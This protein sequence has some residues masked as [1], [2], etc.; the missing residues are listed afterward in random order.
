MRFFLLL[1]GLPLGLWAQIVVRDNA[2]GAPVE[3]AH[4]LFEEEGGRRD[5]AVTDAQGQGPNLLKAP[6]KVTISFVGYQSLEVKLK[7]DQP[8]VVRLLPG[9]QDLREVVVTGQFR[10]QGESQSVFPVKVLKTA[11]FEARGAVTLNQV[12]NNQLNIRISQDN[13]L[14]S[15]ISMQG[16]SGENVKILVDGVPLVGRLNGNIDLS[17]INMAEVERIEVVEGPLSV[18]YGSNALAGTINIITKKPVKGQNT[19]SISQYYE[20]VG[21]FQTDLAGMVALGGPWSA[22]WGG[23][24]YFLDG[25]SPPGLDTGRSLQWNQ[26]EQYNAYAGLGYSGKRLTLYLDGRYLWEQIKDKGERRSAF[27]DY[28]FDTWFTTQ[29]GMGTVSG[30]YTPSA[31]GNLQYM[32][33]YSVFNRSRIRYNT[34]LVEGGQ[35]PTTNPSDHD[36]TRY[37]N[38]VSRSSWNSTTASPWNYQVG[39]DLNWESASGDRIGG[40]VQTMLDVALFGSLQWQPTNRITIQPA[41]RVSYN[42]AFAADPVP[43]LNL[44][45]AASDQWVWRASYARGFR[46]PSI[47]ELHM[48]FIDANHNIIG[49]PNLTPEFSHNLQASATYT[50]IWGTQTLR[51]SPNAFYND[52]YNVIQLAPIDGLRY[53]YLNI[54]NKKTWGGKLE[55]QLNIHPDFSFTAGGS[56]LWQTLNIDGTT[57]ETVYFSPEANLIF[58]YWRPSK[59]FN[60]T[61]SYKF[62]GNTP[63]A[64]VDDFEQVSVITIPSFHLLDVSVTQKLWKNRVELTAGGKNLINYTNFQVTATGGVH[65]SGGNLPIAWGRTFFASL[66]LNLP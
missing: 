66:K 43:S 10:P 18:T 23:N 39:Y 46:A 15:G 45:Y 61:I 51:I 22:K 26:K 33:S 11:D 1:L 55:A 64:A 3:Y 29:R 41:L 6:G 36:T 40:G 65:G 28:A 24:R 38:A 31:R 21:L 19:A 7:P 62:T 5:F 50:R 34:N 59:R 60:F 12:L 17:Q 56:A 20:S 37:L 53:T 30:T 58:S 13:V 48:E 63:L 32:A 47:K 35:T 8:V 54:N 14:G 44:R 2:S 57:D 9:S 4:L 49:N 16:L 42:S 27:S 52:L 25:W